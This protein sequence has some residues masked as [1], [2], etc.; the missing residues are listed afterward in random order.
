MTKLLA[1]VM[2]NNVT[3]IIICSSLNPLP[4]EMAVERGVERCLAL[5]T[6][7]TVERGATVE[8]TPGRGCILLVRFEDI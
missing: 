5:E 3:K 1:R 6:G 4:F 8:R 7:L 2:L